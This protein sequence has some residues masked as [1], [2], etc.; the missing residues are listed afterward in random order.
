MNIFFTCEDIR[1]YYY[2]PRIIYF[3]YVLKARVSETYKMRKG[4]E[5]HEKIKIKGNIKR[6]IYISSEDLSLIGI[7]DAL[8]YIDTNTVDIIEIKQGKLKRKMHDSHKA[9]LAAQAILVEKELGLKVRKIKV[10]DA[11]T[12]KTQEVHIVEYHRE[13]ARKAIEE[14]KKIVISEELPEPTSISGKCI[15]C[16]YR[17]YCDDVL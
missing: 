12:R 7:I 9:Q 6:N 17:A 16:E 15:D 10:L 14:M 1:Q 3:R 13:M 4:S 8:E 11:T 2:C 5:T